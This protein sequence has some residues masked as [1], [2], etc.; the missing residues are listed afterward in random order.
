MC[1]GE[2]E[3]VTQRYKTVLI[4]GDNTLLDFDAA[5]TQALRRTM[6]ARGLAFTPERYAAYTAINR[7]LWDAAHRGEVDRDYITGQRFRRFGETLGW[8]G[9][10]DAWDREYLD[11]LGD[12]GTLLPGAVELLRALKPHCVIGL[13]TNGLQRVQRRRLAGNPITPYLDGVFIS[14]EMGVGKPEAAYFR[15]AL[16][17]L[18]AKAETTVMVGDDLLSDIQGA[19]NAGLDSIWYSRNGAESPLPTYRVTDLGAVAQI[20]LGKEK[21]RA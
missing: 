9:D 21:E 3:T 13:A 6:E 20:V 8:S 14:Q 11:A 7:A 17:A 18:D 12:C 2:G 1:G 10:A 4:D 16:E 15:R 5:E 19:I